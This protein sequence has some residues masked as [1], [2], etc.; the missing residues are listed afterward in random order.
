[1]LGGGRLQMTFMERGALDE[2]EIYI[3][4]EIIGG[5]VPLFPSTGFKASPTLISAKD[6]GRGCVRLHHSVA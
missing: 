2:I 4:P 1:M 6:I 5:G 3:I